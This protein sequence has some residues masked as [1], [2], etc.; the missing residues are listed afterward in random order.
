MLFGRRLTRE[1]DDLATAVPGPSPEIRWREFRPLPAKSGARLAPPVS[2]AIALPRAGRG[3]GRG[4]RLSLIPRILRR[5]PSRDPAEHAADGHA[6]SRR[7][8]LA[9]HVAGHDL[10]GGEHVGG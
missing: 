2:H 4:N 7:I 10:A 9:E 8:A 5:F 1:V 6:D 3:N